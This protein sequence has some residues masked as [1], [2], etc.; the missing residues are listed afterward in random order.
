MENIK[1]YYD[2]HTHLDWYENQELL[3]QQLVDTGI[4]CLAASVDVESYEKNLKIAEK[5]NHL[6]GKKL[7][8]PIFGIH[9]CKIKDF[10]EEIHKQKGQSKLNFETDYLQK[11]QSKLLELMDTSPI[12][13]EIGMD[14]CWYKDASP[15]Q[16]EA[17]FRYFLNHCNKYK[18]YCVIHTKDAEQQIADI[19]LDYPDAKPIIHWY[20]GPESIYRE[21]IRRQ[22]MTTFGCETSRSEHIQK[23]LKI[24]PPELILCETDNPTGETWLGGK[25]NSPMLIKRVYEDT[26]KVLGMSQEAFT[27]QMKK[28]WEKIT[29]V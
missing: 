4:Y 6:A 9:P 17:V 3:V 2:S 11:G 19:L 16:Q 26:A 8:I 1:I 24:T 23:L 18:K 27:L 21:F 13:G 29:G 5:V 25:D 7:V 12:I 28:N 10:L 15:Q 20:D 14:F 22:Y